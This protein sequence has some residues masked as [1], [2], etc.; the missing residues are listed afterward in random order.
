MLQ[1]D[2]SWWDKTKGESHGCLW[3]RWF[4]DFQEEVEE[5]RTRL[6]LYN[7]DS[8]PRSAS[9]TGRRPSETSSNNSRYV[10]RL[11]AGVT[12]F[13]SN[14]NFFPNGRSSSSNSQNVSSS[15]SYESWHRRSDSTSSPTARH[16]SD[17][18]V[19]IHFLDGSSVGDDDE[20]ADTQSQSQHSSV[21]GNL[22]EWYHDA[23]T[24]HEADRDLS[25]RNSQIR[26]TSYGDIRQGDVA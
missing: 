15:N 4:G 12:P 19:V 13:A 6:M 5:E 14:S 23:N 10:N 24:D 22:T 20:R 17:G 11:N 7:N 8:R 16:V 1:T 2:G 26:E 21:H 18:A 3:D 9:P 25:R